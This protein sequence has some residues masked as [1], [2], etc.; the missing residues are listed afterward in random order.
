M[1][2]SFARQ[3]DKLSKMAE[4]KDWD[5]FGST[6]SS[7]RSRYSKYTDA[8]KISFLWKEIEY[9]F[10]ID[11]LKSEKDPK[12]E[13]DY[14]PIIKHYETLLTLHQKMRESQIREIL[15][16]LSELHMASGN[17]Q[18]ALDYHHEWLGMGV[19]V[20]PDKKF[21]I[22]QTHFFLEQYGRSLEWVEEAIADV[23]AAGQLPKERWYA[24]QKFIYSE[25]KNSKKVAEILEILVTHFPKKR[26]W[27][28]L[29]V[30]YQQDLERPL[31]ALYI[32]D[33]LFMQDQLTKSTFLKAL[34]YG[35]NSNGAPYQMAKVYEY[36]LEKG[37]LEETPKHLKD[38]F[39]TL[40]Q[41]GERKKSISVLERY[42]KLSNND[43]EML[44]ILAEEYINS[45][46]YQKAIDTARKSQK[47]KDKA[48]KP[49]AS[50]FQEGVALFYLKKYSDSVKALQR[51]AKDPKVKGTADP[52][53]GYVKSRINELKSARELEKQLRE[54]IAKG[55]G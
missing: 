21:K 28:E 4:E 42:V 16:T 27:Q 38:L 34:A 20:K 39:F 13:S 45:G 54:E 11:G 35:Y 53:I 48:R 44:N 24:T 40:Q 41:A 55:V 30:V 7:M 18:K 26:Y 15:N 49:G 1:G 46:A 19:E 5:S 51:A 6:L 29:G 37:Y 43:A 32:F 2:N 22:G 52:W 31:D 50:H 23:K 47:A 3:F 36:G 17:F 12:H 10:A 8:E 9:A 14:G 33:S 25:Q